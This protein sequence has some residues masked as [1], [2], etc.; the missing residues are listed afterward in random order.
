MFR[1]VT[2]AAAALALAACSSGSDD[3]DT[4]GDGTISAE[5]A[6]AAA[7]K[8][9]PLEAG[10]YKVKMEIVEIVDPQAKP[11]E[12]EQAKKFFAT[13]SEMAPPRC[14]NEEEAKDGMMGIAESIQ[15][16]DCTVEKMTSNADGMTSDMTCKAPSGD[17]KVKMES[18]STGTEGEMTMTVTEP[19][20][21]SA[22]KRV[23]MKVGMTRQGDCKQ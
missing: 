16:G 3:G 21:N 20:G 6:S 23:V 8:M 7:A 11:E 9:R 17:A 14:L 4:D 10:E 1:F 13:M 22:E 2:T 15:S 12:I 19:S 18:T 5:E